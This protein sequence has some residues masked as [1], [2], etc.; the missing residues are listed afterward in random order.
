M[1]FGALGL[2]FTSAVEGA[3][4]GATIMV[5]TRLISENG[6]GNSITI[7]ANVLTGAAM[8]AACAAV[9]G[10]VCGVITFVL[11]AII[12]TAALMP[13]EVFAP[14][15]H[16]AGR[17]SVWGIGAGGFAGAVN[18]CLYCL[19][20]GARANLAFST[21]LFFGFVYGVAAGFI[22][23]SF[24]GALKGARDEMKRQRAEETILESTPE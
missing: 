1:F 19:L 22:I 23:G 9:V 14:S 12:A 16:L 17:N 18:G 2:A 7:L 13:D 6:I 20:F 5:L 21:C 24:H 11:V 10:L 4:C 15:F 3:L 8:G